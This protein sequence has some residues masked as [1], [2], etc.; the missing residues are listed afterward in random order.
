MNELPKDQYSIE[1]G[2]IYEQNSKFPLFIDPQ[3]QANKWIK[4]LELNNGLKVT[5]Q[6]DT[7]FIRVLE[8]A[9]QLG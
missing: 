4:N 9:I 6:T 7:D 1:N 5:K 3:L 8:T 2:L